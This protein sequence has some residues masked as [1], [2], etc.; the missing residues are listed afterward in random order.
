MTIADNVESGLSHA[1]TDFVD[2]SPPDGPHFASN[3]TALDKYICNVDWTH[4]RTSSQR[5]VHRENWP[6]KASGIE[7]MVHVIDK[8]AMIARAINC[9]YQCDVYYSHDRGAW[10]L[11]GRYCNQRMCPTCAARLSYEWSQRIQA[12]MQPIIPHKWRLITLTLRS[13]DAPL[14]DQLDLLRQ[15]FRRLRQTQLWSR[16]QNYGRAVIEIT[17]NAERKQWHPHLHVIGHGGYIKHGELADNWERATG[18]SHIVH[19]VEVRKT[20]EAA[21]YLAKYTSKGSACL[22]ADD[23]PELWRELVLATVGRKMVIRYGEQANL[24]AY[25][26]VKE[27][28]GPDDWQLIGS[29]PQVMRKADKHDTVMIMHLAGLVAQLDLGRYILIPRACSGGP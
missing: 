2:S 22:N 26:D 5:C 12:W 17:Y 11:R 15:S 9:A 29:L 18:G 10:Q 7:A 8:P 4:P 16:T 19:I 24:P 6:L 23:S 27:W 25:A 21:N 13:T 28:D 1:P 14:V 20:K 3:L